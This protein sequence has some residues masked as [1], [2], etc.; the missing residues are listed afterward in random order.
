MTPKTVQEISDWL[1]E[2]ARATTDL[3]DLVGGFG[4]RMV[5][6][7]MGLGRLSVGT[8]VLH[9]TRGSQTVRWMRGGGLE[10]EGFDTAS[11]ATPNWLMS[12]IRAAIDA[13]DRLIRRRLETDDPGSEFPILEDLKA[14]GYTDYV[15][16]ATPF[17]AFNRPGM[18]SGAV[19]SW[20]S[21][22]AGGFS[23]EEIAA[24]ERLQPRLTVAIKSAVLHQIATDV[25]TIYLGAD[26]GRRVLSGEIDRGG[27]RVLNVAL[28]FCDLRGF[29]AL[30]DRS[31][32]REMI[33]LLDLYFDLIAAPLE[34]RGGQ[35]LKFMGDGLL[36]TFDLDE[37]PA[38]RICLQALDAAAD[39]LAAIGRTN[40]ERRSAGQ[41]ALDLDIALHVGDVTYGNVGAHDRLDFTVIGPAVNEASRM[42]SLSERLDTHLVI[43]ASFVAAAGAEAAQRFRPLG[44]RKLRGIPVRRD[45]FTLA[46]I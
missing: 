29:S 15:I 31:D 46:E 40:E 20:A 17:I 34:A 42:E 10:W 32:L 22:R 3:Q 24:I 9:P 2:A 21:D 19:V 28:F 39:V 8:H 23:D 27:V 35:V 30:A 33:A 44:K 18:P 16:L 45:L 5:A 37:G 36:A 6:A 26:A 1:I 14:Q 25:V 43:S 7:G 4:E 12:P 13:P 11:M 41:P 38:A